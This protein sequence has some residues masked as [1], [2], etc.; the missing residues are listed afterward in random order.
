MSG[1]RKPE[2]TATTYAILGLLAAGPSS[3]YDL[4]IR[5][6]TGY[7]YF[8]PRARSHVF[9]EAK[10]LAALGWATGT[11]RRT[12]QRTRTEYTI[13]AQGRSALEGWLATEPVTFTMEFEH[14]V[15]IYLAGFG[16]TADLLRVLDNASTRANEMLAIAERVISEYEAGVIEGPQDEPH[17]RV[18]LVDYL[19]NLAALTS[20]WA[21]RSR[22]DI[23]Q[24]STGD[25][26]ARRGRAVR[27]MSNLPRSS[28]P[29]R[30]PV[31]S[32]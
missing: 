9:T 4:S 27:R 7:A 2:P 31:S 18:L 5:L 1:K 32:G 15:R 23:A 8:W 16:T 26:S 30:R 24:W 19:A 10:K 12:G 14:L 6:R 25:E 21:E 3:P 28:D 13:T 17:L 20:D 29:R 22:Q 11:V